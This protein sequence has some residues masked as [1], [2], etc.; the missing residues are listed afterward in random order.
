MK[1]AERLAVA[2]VIAIVLAVIGGAFGRSYWLLELL[3][4]FQLQYFIALTVC[5]IVLL[6][7]RSYGPAAMTLAACLVALSSIA[8]PPPP[9]P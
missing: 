5:F 9:A 4:H 3:S 6:L 7:L 8:A 2:L 1:F